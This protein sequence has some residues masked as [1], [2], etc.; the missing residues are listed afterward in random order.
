[1]PKEVWAAAQALPGSAE[2]FPS[3][4]PPHAAGHAAVTDTDEDGGVEFDD[5]GEDGDDASPA[6]PSSPSVGGGGGGGK[7]K[8]LLRSMGSD[9][10]S[11]VSGGKR[12]K[13]EHCFKMLE[14]AGAG[15]KPKRLVT[16]S[17]AVAAAAA[18]VPVRGTR[19][20]LFAPTG[21]ALQAFRAERSEAT[22]SSSTSR[23]T[24]SSSAAAG[25]AVSLAVSLPEGIGLSVVDDFGDSASGL[26]GSG[27]A[28]LRREVLYLAAGG[29]ALALSHDAN[30]D[31]ADL[32]LQ[33]R[34]RGAGLHVHSGGSF[35]RRAGTLPLLAS[36][37]RVRQRLFSHAFAPPFWLPL[38]KRF[39]GSNW[40]IFFAARLSPWRSQA[41]LSRRPKPG[42]RRPPKRHLRATRAWRL[43]AA[44]SNE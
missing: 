35:C 3:P 23:R 10:S 7:K 6:S 40:T 32:V 28:S 42:T 27:L 30:A 15:A 9:L 43:P 18:V 1:V 22:N 2:A 20:L 44:P 39:A 31:Q 38:S 13:Q 34:A 21:K 4:A 11:A 12:K 8:G 24:G 16:F 17:G 41:A 5:D 26:V 37:P 19:L 25:L 29:I 14:M 36:R 33:A